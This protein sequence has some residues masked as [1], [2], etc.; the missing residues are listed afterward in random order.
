ML[1]KGFDLDTIVEITGLKPSEIE[2][3]REVSN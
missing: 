3:L 1:K 2:K